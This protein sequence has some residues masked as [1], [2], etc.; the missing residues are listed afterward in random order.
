MKNGPS[1][2][3]EMLLVAHAIVTVIN[4]GKVVI[5]K[6]LASINITEI[7]SVVRYGISVVNAMNKRNSENAKIIYQAKQTNEQW[8]Q[9]DGDFSEQEKDYILNSPEDLVIE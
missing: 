6:N 1:K 9:I 3:N 4:V 2:M 8:L 5:T 7:F